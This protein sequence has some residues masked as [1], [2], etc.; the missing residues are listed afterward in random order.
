MPDEK[1]NKPAPHA[2]S[3][4]GR[5]KVVSGR[6]ND[7]VKA[8]DPAMSPLGTDAKLQVRMTRTA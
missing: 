3:P 6:T 2:A 1:A 8:F 7:K 5:E 4:Q